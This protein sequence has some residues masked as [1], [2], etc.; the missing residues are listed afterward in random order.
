MGWRSFHDDDGIYEVRRE[1][2]LS[3]LVQQYNLGDCTRQLLF[4]HH[5]D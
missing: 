4:E 5:N 3:V 2:N 1:V